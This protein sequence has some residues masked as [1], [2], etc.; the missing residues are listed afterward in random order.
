MKMG[1]N[2]DVQKNIKI[3]AMSQYLYCYITVF[4]SYPYI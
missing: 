2:L 1:R 4:V 3:Y